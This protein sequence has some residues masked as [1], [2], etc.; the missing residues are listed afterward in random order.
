MTKL[1]KSIGNSNPL[2]NT[3]SK[4]TLKDYFDSIPEASAPRQDFL[5]KMMEK[6]GCPYSTVRSWFVYGIKP[7]EERIIGILQEETGIAPEEMWQD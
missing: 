7:R 3:E 2:G 4:M 5:K 1:M 6:T